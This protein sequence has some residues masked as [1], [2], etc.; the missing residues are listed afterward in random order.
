MLNLWTLQI[1]DAEVKKKYDEERVKNFN[2]LHLPFSI[3]ILG[4]VLYR[5]KKVIFDG[6][7]PALLLYRGTMLLLQIVWGIIKWKWEDKVRPEFVFIRVGVTLISYLSQHYL[8]EYLPE[9]IQFSDL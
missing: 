8:S 4:W 1:K 7:T 5:V 6:D 9:F 3:W 2:A